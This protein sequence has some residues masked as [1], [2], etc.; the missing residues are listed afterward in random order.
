MYL[1]I[2]RYHLYSLSPPKK[3]D[4]NRLDYFNNA[5][6][7]KH[8]VRKNMV[9]EA[10]SS[11]AKKLPDSRG[12]L[13]L[14]FFIPSCVLRPSPPPPPAPTSFSKCVSARGGFDLIFH[15][16]VWAVEQLHGTPWSQSSSRCYPGSSW[17]WQYTSSRRRSSS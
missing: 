16:W 9:C 7:L 12:F 11:L 1:I 10:V 13:G 3:Y 8:P 4:K 2:F 6:N 14:V 15:L 17:M 5:N